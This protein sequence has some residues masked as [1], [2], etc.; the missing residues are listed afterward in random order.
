M[1]RISELRHKDVIS[2]SDGKRLGYIRD[3]EIDLEKGCIE[4]II[5]PEEARFFTLFGKS[6]ETTLRWRQIQKIG[7]DVILVEQESP[8]VTLR[9]RAARSSPPEE[10]PAE[11]SLPADALDEDLDFFAF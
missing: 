5:I 4:S 10:K 3:I 11:H 7:V 2:S 9:E 6:D 1:I 8:A